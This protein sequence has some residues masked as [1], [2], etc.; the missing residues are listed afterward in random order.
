MHTEFEWDDQLLVSLTRD[1]GG[2]RDFL[3]IFLL[4][5]RGS[6]FQSLSEFAA[7]FPQLAGKPGI[8]VQMGEREALLVQQAVPLPDGEGAAHIGIDRHSLL[9][10]GD[11]YTALVVWNSPG[12]Y[13]TYR[14]EIDL[15]REGLRFSDN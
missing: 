9:R 12:L 8:P 5:V 7:S 11:R 2:R 6:R 15:L 10:D 3:K 13:E 1:L 14:S 4:C